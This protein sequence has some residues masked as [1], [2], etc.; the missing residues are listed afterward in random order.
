MDFTNP[1]RV[2][3]EKSL[4]LSIKTLTLLA[5]LQPEWWSVLATIPQ[6]FNSGSGVK[7]RSDLI[8]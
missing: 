3:E 6:R 5:Y 8:L 1:Y 4:C 7:V 2:I